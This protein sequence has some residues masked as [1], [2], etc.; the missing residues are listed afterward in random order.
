MEVLICV[1]CC[2]GLIAGNLAM[3][4]HYKVDDDKA[5][6]SVPACEICRDEIGVEEAELKVRDSIRTPGSWPFTQ[7]LG[8]TAANIIPV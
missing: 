2:E 4:H 8:C 5:V 6:P 1:E 3:E 7:T